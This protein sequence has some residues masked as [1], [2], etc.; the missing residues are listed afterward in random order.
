M[1]SYRDTREIPRGSKS[2]ERRLNKAAAEGVQIA[3]DR[4]NQQKKAWETRKAKYGPS[5]SSLSR[6]ASHLASNHYKK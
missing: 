5:G 1:R 2:F 4:E 6:A 3:I